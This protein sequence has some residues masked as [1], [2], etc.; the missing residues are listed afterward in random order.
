MNNI[1]KSTAWVFV[2]VIVA[3]TNLMGQQVTKVGTTAAKFLSIPVGARALGMGGAFVAVANDASAMYWNPSGLAGMYQTEALFS[4]ANWIAGIN[5]NYAG[6]VLPMGDFGTAGLN[7]T[8]VSMDDMERT[9]ED[10]PEGTGEFFSA[11]SFAVGVSF[12]RKLTDWF[13]IGG[14]VKYINEHIWNSNATGFAVDVGTLFTTPFSGL[15]FGVTISNFG[16]KMRISGDD[17]LVL[18]PVSTN[19]GANQSVNANLSTDGFDLPLDLRIGLAYQPIADDERELTL[20]VDA[21]HPNDNSESLDF[22]GEFSALQKI[23]SV[24]AGYK[25]LGAKDSEEQFTVGG[26]LR[27]EI[28]D[29]L[30]VRVDYAYEKFGLLENVHK[31]SVGVLF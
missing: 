19:N 12:S 4:H 10:Q 8:S 25:A 28:S 30:I 14:N 31:F 5:F 26:G 2:A 27:Y 23:L 21:S 24:R 7:F 15:K 13:D 18:K 1:A 22:G 17:L 29:G 9:T 20:A 16:T 3:T 6:V 11:G